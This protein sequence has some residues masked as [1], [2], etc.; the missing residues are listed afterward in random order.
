[1][2]WLMLDIVFLLDLRLWF[3]QKL[4]LFAQLT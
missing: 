4:S 3:E 2:V 1:L